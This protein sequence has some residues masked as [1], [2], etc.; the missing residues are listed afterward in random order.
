MCICMYV[1]MYFIKQGDA[2]NKQTPRGRVGQGRAVEWS[3]V[4]RFGS[5]RFYRRGDEDGDE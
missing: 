5:V 1:C 2:N 4:V 3:G